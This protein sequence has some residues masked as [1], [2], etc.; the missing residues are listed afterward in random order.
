MMSEYIAEPNENEAYEEEIVD[1]RD[2]VTSISLTVN[3]NEVKMLFDKGI[4]SKREQWE[5]VFVYFKLKDWI[6]VKVTPLL[7][8]LIQLK[9]ILGEGNEAVLDIATYAGYLKALSK[10]TDG[11]VRW[12]DF[13][14]YDPDEI[15]PVPHID[16]GRELQEKYDSCEDYY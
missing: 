8:S 10:S 16:W 14:V 11:I 2:L 12:G 15:D 7:A 13:E 3:G 6:I 9:F 5:H 4:M 1:L